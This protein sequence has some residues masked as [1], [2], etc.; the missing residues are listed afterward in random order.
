[1]SLNLYTKDQ[2]VTLKTKNGPVK[3]VVVEAKLDKIKL[4][5]GNKPAL[6]SDWFPVDDVTPFVSKKLK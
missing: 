1:M 6:P 5:V 4:K 3:A 2:E